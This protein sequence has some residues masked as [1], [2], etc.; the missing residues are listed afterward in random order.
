MK[1]ACK[2]CGKQINTFPTREHFCLAEAQCILGDI[3]HDMR[4]VHGR[5]MDL[6]RIMRH[7][8]TQARHSKYSKSKDPIEPDET[9]TDRGPASGLVYTLS[10]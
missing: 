10:N 5:M 4:I 7:L 3:T 1:I 2:F 9:L 6:E 8:M